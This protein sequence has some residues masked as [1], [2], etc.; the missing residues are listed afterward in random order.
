MD[1][2]DA[3]RLLIDVA[4]AG[5]FSAV[6][7]QRS[8]ATSTA[9][10]AVG[11]LEQEA[12][13][14]L[15]MRSTRRLVLTREGDDFVADARRIVAEWDAA[16]TGLRQDGPLAGQIRVTATN[17]FGRARLRPLLDAFQ[18]RH[19]AI[20]IALLLS[21]SALDLIDGRIDLAVRSG[22]LPDSTLR[23]RLLVRGERLVCAAPGYWAAH[24]K[25]AH[26]IDLAAHNCLVLARPDAPL[27]AWTFQEAGRPLSVRVT[28]DRQVS[29]GDVLR[30][31]AMAGLGVAF[32]N[33]WDIR[34]ACEAGLL[35]TALE[36]FGAGR[37]DLYAV[38][39]GALPARRVSALVE[40]LAEAFAG[41]R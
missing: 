35:D 8:I 5:S 36:N 24:G 19:P 33:A 34:Q 11:Q 27:A 18:L 31:W 20:H 3:L 7:R 40:F 21:D 14:Q 28:G 23:A 12:G 39:P 6:A 30:E 26:P 4:E 37:V 41:E 32:K 10:L 15:M 16:L 2:I 38:Q 25:P 1:R 29:D 9:T 17:D 22:P 13:V